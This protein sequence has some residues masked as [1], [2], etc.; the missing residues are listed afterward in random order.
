MNEIEKH[1]IFS[2]GRIEK[3]LIDNELENRRNDQ[4]NWSEI[5]IFEHIVLSNSYLLEIAEELKVDFDL[6]KPEG[7][8]GDFTWPH[9]DRIKPDGNK[10]VHRPGP[11]NVEGQTTTCL[12]LQET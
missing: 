4:N 3:Y 9:A 6:D 8:R 12:P 7:V 11:V 1:L 2:F 10:T 5:E